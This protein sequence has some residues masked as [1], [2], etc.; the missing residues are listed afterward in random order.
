MR[1]AFLTHEPFYPSSGG[2]SIEAIYLIEAM[3]RRG[4]E[5]DVYCPSFESP[6]HF[7]QAPWDRVTFIQFRRW[8]M[9]RYTRLRNFKYLMFPSQ[10]TQMM[11][12]RMQSGLEYDVIWGQHSISCVAAGR[13]RRK[14]SP[15]RTRIVM[16]YLDLL[17]GFMENWPRYLAPRLLLNQLTRFEL[18]TPIKYGA[19]LVFTVS[20]ELINRFEEVG[21]QRESLYPFYFGIDTKLFSRA[22]WNPP[23]NSG[24]QPEIVMHGS[25]DHHHLGPLALEATR[26]VLQKNPRVKFRFIGKATKAWLS[27][28]KSLRESGADVS[29]VIHQDFIP[30][31]KL[32]ETLSKCHVGW[33]PYEP[34][35]G[36]HSAFIAKLVEYVALG[37]PSVCGKLS[38]V[39][40]YFGNEP[41]VQFTEFDPKALAD[42]LLLALN[43]PIEV[44]RKHSE[45]LRSKVLRDLDWRALCNRAL[46]FLEATQ[47]KKS[48]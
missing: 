45:E 22:Q 36:T 6:S 44:S 31:E 28:I 26:L 20:E 39:S 25:F 43:T 32:P 7:E 48:L 9:G 29:R 8:E 16:N 14:T 33:V 42:G 13:M 5:V 10:L 12:D 2:G 30:Y 24:E 18:R 4:Y 46:D 34:S 38:G 15:D 23:G 1:L 27:F 21:V 40:K 3:A 19:D 17:T 41:L 37:M 47:H 11:R 35:S